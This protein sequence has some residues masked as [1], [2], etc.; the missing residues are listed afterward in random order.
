M[1]SKKTLA[2]TFTKKK[3]LVDKSHAIPLFGFDQCFFM[4]F[5]VILFQRLSSSFD[6]W[7]TDHILKTFTKFYLYIE[8]LKINYCSPDS[9]GLLK[10]FRKQTDKNQ[11]R[12]FSD[13]TVI[14]L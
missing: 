9:R 7:K 13:S 8:I 1:T 14:L 12:V 6:L 3:L 5:S 10:Q 2:A 11:V 4:H